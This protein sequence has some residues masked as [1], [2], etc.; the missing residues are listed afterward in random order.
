MSPSSSPAGFHWPRPRL[1]HVLWLFALCLAIG[2]WSGAT[3]WVVARD[4][5]SLEPWIESFVLEITA[6]LA[7]WIALYAPAAAVANAPS[8][9]SGWPKFLLFNATGF[10]LFSALKSSLML[11]SRAALHPLLGLGR[12]SHANMDFVME[13]MKDFPVYIVLLAGWAFYQLRQQRQRD[14]LRTAELRGELREVQLRAITNQLNPHFLFN[15]L[16]TV[17][18]V[19]YADLEKTDRLLSELG[20]LLRASLETD[21]ATWPL[22][23]E[24]AHTER[25]I[26]IMAARFEE[27]LRV[28]WEL[29][30]DLDAAE[31]PRFVL[32][33][34]VE[35]AIKHNAD[36]K[37]GVALFVRGRRVR[38]QM[39]ED[40]LV[41]E[42]EDDG[43]GFGSSP[44]EGT[45]V[46]LSGLSRAME[47][48][49]GDRAGMTVGA[50]PAGGALVRLHLPVRA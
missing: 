16:N 29:A 23:E 10:V 46:G 33:R 34:L 41:L 39:G 32:Q 36:R 21:Q 14:L 13:A 22:R 35:N 5:G 27:R 3:R 20:Q 48:L 25:F 49:Y 15:A 40:D 31:V 37:M 47:L 26:Y 4:E 44:F 9:A 12:Y 11:A 45:G 30:P 42:V 1:N 6:S 17:S 8:P 7:A 2:L 43:R 19:M 18:S 28:H 38:G 24:R 50:G